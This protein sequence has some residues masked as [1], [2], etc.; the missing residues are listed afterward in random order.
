[1]IRELPIQ[2]IVTRAEL[3]VF[4]GNWNRWGVDPLVNTQPKVL[5]H[6]PWR[7]V[8]IRPGQAHILSC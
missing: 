4:L 1:M 6:T 7:L 2:G 3:M 8:G 5:T